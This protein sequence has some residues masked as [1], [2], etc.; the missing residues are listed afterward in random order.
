[1][2]RQREPRAAGLQHL[3]D[4]LQQAVA[5]LEHDA[6]EL[7][8]LVLVEIAGLERLQVQTNRRHRRLQLVRNGVDEGVVLFVAPDLTHQ[9]DGV[10]HH[11]GDD[12]DEEDDAQ[13]DQ[14]RAV[15]VEHD[16][17]DVEG[18]RERDQADAEDGEEDDRA[19]ATADHNAEV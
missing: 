15:P 6:V 16:P 9:E 12:G 2:R 13:H 5:V 10:E 17:A 18:D 14:H 4:R 19:A 7:A 11:A 3:L 1:M 8:A